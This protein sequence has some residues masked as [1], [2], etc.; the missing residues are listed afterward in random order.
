MQSCELTARIGSELEEARGWKCRSEEQIQ[1]T[2]CASDLPHFSGGRGSSGSLDGGV[3]FS[4][5]TPS[6]LLAGPL[7][8]R[9][10]AISECS[11][12]TQLAPGA[13]QHCSPEHRKI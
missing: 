5:A 1:S 9:G 10:G 4:V 13:W 3:D 2:S 7:A 6:V 8:V 12:T 11:L